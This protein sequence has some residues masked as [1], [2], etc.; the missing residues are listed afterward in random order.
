[1]AEEAGKQVVVTKD[2]KA[3]APSVYNPFQGMER[4]FE[5]FMGR[6][7]MRPLPWDRLLGD[8]SPALLPTFDVK[9][10]PRVDVVDGDEQI[11]VRAELPGVEKDDVKV[12]LAGNLIT[13]KAETKRETKEDKAEVHRCEIY[14]GSY[15]RTFT[16]PS[17]VDESRAK[18]SMKDGILEIVMPKVEATKRHSIKVS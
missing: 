5:D 9:G 12:T 8:F 17:A 3:V 18:A 14:R 15:L 10:T 1:M 11:T 4:L 7:W 16:L 2:E 13:I 6:V